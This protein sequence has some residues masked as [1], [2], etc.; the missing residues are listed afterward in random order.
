MTRKQIFKL[1]ALAVCSAVVFLVVP[2]NGGSILML[3][4]LPF[5]MVGNGLRELSLSG[6][7]GNMAAICIYGIICLLP[8]IP[9][10]RKKWAREDWLLLL[11]SGA[12][13]YVLYLMI[14]PALM[15]QQMN[16]DM[17][18]ALLSG[19][20]YS[21]FISWGIL[22]LLHKEDM[23]GKSGGYKAIRLLLG[24]CA[25]IYIVQG[26]GIGTGELKTAVET[27]HSGNTMPG[28]N[29]LPTD[30]FL[31]L[32][33]AVQALEY[34]LD[35]CLMIHGINLIQELE[36]DP[37]SEGCV[38]T[39][40]RFSKKARTYLTVILLSNITLNVAQVLLASMLY[41]IDTTVR[42]PV[43]S[44]ALCLGSMA[45]AK[46]LG[47]GKEIKEENDLYI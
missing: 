11:G 36:A 20:V 16:R 13:F 38:S 29:L 5:Q 43:F 9:L 7:V 46:L 17:G 47:Q 24:A 21:I 35:A 44:T 14:N 31:L 15:P 12:L 42:I 19:T 40:E 30:C 39:A 8:V 4:G 10:F 6:K 28:Q 2:G 3:A 18:S 22:K 25:V 27:V 45:L 32:S 41:R 1:F 23:L 37:Y 34:T 26:Y 33:F